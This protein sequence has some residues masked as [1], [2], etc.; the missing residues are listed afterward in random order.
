MA[1]NTIF[2][3]TPLTFDTYISF[4]SCGFSQENLVSVSDYTMVSHL[5]GTSCIFP[6]SE[7][8][9]TQPMQR[10]VSAII[11]ESLLIPVQLEKAQRRISTRISSVRLQMK[12]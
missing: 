6:A 8:S 3:L 1:R 7:V 10:L 11:C 2:D 4:K 5:C 9:H 12:V